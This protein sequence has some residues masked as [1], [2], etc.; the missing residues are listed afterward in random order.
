MSHA[1]L[2]AIALL[3]F[4]PGVAR[5]QITDITSGRPDG[6]Y[7]GGLGL[8]N[9]YERPNTAEDLRRNEIEVKY[10]EVVRAKI[11]DKKPSNDPWKSVRPTAAAITIDRH[12]PQ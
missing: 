11:P 9:A 10:R 1:P 5:A 6:V 3:A 12:R 7:Y 8:T 4:C 2:L